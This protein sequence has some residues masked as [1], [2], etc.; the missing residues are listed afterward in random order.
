MARRLSELLERIRPAGSPGAA[1]TAEPNVERAVADEIS[2]LVDALRPFEDEV[3]AELDAARTRAEAIYA[4][5][6]RRA[7][8]VRDGAAERIALETAAARASDRTRV[9]EERHRIAEATAV[10]IARR[11]ERADAARDVLAARVIDVLRDLAADES[12]GRT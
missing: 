6:E 2:M 1:G 10:E 9:E 7:A 8:L 4:D 12:V 3:D 5:G 11:R